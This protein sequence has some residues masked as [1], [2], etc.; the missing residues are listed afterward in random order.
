MNKYSERETHMLDYQGRIS[1]PATVSRGP[2]YVSAVI[3]YSLAY[4]ATDVID[5]NYLATTFS[6]QVQISIVLIGTVRKPAIESIVL[7]KRWGMTNEKAQKPIQV[8]MQR[9][10]MTMLHP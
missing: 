4:N 8:T 5:N 1:I 6:A 2:V 3:L 10:I 9:G 7:A